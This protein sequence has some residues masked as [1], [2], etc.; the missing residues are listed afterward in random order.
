MILI[1]IV[2]GAN[3]CSDPR[4]GFFGLLL[5]TLTGTVARRYI[6]AT[7]YPGGFLMDRTAFADAFYQ[8]LRETYPLPKKVYVLLKLK[9]EYMIPYPGGLASGRA[10]MQ[11]DVGVIV[12]AM[13]P[14]SDQALLEFIA[15]EY[16]HLLQ[17][18]KHKTFPP[19]LVLPPEDHPL[20]VQA[21]KFGKKQAALYMERL[22]KAA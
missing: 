3:P 10:V 19:D 20:E 11:G 16:K 18:F 5:K 1:F 8:Y 13:R 14:L 21:R 12:I 6:S 15:H 9:D 4:K 22:P 2:R 17:R 7:L